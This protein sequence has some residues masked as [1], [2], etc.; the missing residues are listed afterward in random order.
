MLPLLVLRRLDA[1]LEPTKAAVLTKAAD[2]RRP[3][4]RDP[5]PDLAKTAGQSFYN[6]SPL[7][8]DHAAAGRQERGRQ[9]SRV[10][11]RVL[12]RA[13]WRC[14]RST[15]S[16]TR[17]TRLDKAGILYQVL[18]DFADLDLHPDTVSNEAM[19]YDLR[20]TAAQVLGDEQ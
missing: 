4:S 6:T 11:Q 5:G 10:R 1:V 2:L 19:G 3:G 12:V 17:S 9:P 18:G 13:R 16:T 20:G 15:G 7:I 14:W 8:A